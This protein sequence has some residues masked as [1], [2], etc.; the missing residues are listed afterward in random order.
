MFRIRKE[1]RMAAIV[2][3][4]VFCVLNL[5]NIIRYSN[6]FT[7]LGGDSWRTFIR[8]WH[9]SG[10]DPIT[11]S[12]LTSWSSGYN[13]FRHPLLAYF[14][15]PFSK[16]NELLISLTGVNCA[17]VIT[18]LLLVFFATYAFVFLSRI[19]WEI[20]GTKRCEAYVLTTMAFSFAFVMLST[21][22]P[23]HF[24]PSMFCLVLTL[25]LCGRKLERGRALN[26]WQTVLMFFFTAGISLN[27]GLKV[28]LAALVTRRKRFFRPGYLVCAVLLP[29]AL[30]WG[31]ARMSYK[32][33]VWPKEV[34]RN[35][36]AK[37]NRQAQ[38]ERL[39]KKAIAK[40]D[41]NDTARI[42]AVKDSVRQQLETN[43]ERRK[44]MSA[45]YKHTGKPMAKGE[46]MRWTDVST[47]RADVAVECLFGEG[48][49]LHEDYLL[50]DVLVNRPVIV[51]YN[52]WFNYIVEAILLLCFAAGVWFGR[53]SLFL[54]TAMSFLLMDMALHMGLGF[55][56]NEIY[57]MSPHYLFVLPIAMAFMLKVLDER[58]R[59]WATIGLGVLTAYLFIWNVTLLSE[60]LFIL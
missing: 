34:E 45:A 25:Y 28:F 56:I 59:R 43:R 41:I 18:A 27:N 33:F 44:K 29:S 57:I 58:K 54:W 23:D 21:L 2:A 3:S 60:Y 7:A 16:L 12:V 53:R 50:A 51:R 8:G 36:K 9:I 17:I 10:F 49:M 15:W 13:I 48:V 31:A 47:S 24:C 26:W 32:Y 30:M 22:V 11:Y 20:I 19:F 42:A 6:T 52:N 5:L 40:I 39:Q 14:V 46:F 55:G 38:L 1:E 4:L 37:Q 35:E